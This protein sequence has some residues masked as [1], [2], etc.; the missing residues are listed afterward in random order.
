MIERFAVSNFKSIRNTVEILFTEG[1]SRMKGGHVSDDGC[2]RV[3]SIFGA[4]A[5]GK[6]NLIKALKFVKKI[7]TDPYYRTQHPACHWD[8]KDAVS[9]F[10]IDFTVSDEMGGYDTYSYSLDVATIE[11]GGESDKKRH[12]YEYEILREGLAVIDR[13]GVKREVFDKENETGKSRISDLQIKIETEQE[14]L[15]SYQTK[16]DLIV[17]EMTRAQNKLFEIESEHRLVL[18]VCK[19]MSIIASPED[20]VREK[21]DDLNI[22]FGDNWRTILGATA[23]EIWGKERRIRNVSVHDPSFEHPVEDEMSIGSKGFFDNRAVDPK[24]GRTTASLEE[25]LASISEDELWRFILPLM[26]LIHSSKGFD[27]S[28]SP[29][30]SN[31]KTRTDFEL[32]A[33]STSRLKQLEMMR[34][35]INDLFDDK[36]KESTALNEMIKMTVESIEIKRTKLIL[37]KNTDS[38]ILPV[39]YT[40]KYENPQKDVKETRDYDDKTTRKMIEKA[41]RWFVSTL[42]ILETDDYYLPIKEPNLLDNISA[43]LSS[44]DVGIDGLGW[45]NTYCNDKRGHYDIKEIDLIKSRL[46]QKDWERLEKCRRNSIDCSCSTSLIVKTDSELNLFTY[47]MGEE[48]VKKLVTY[49]NRNRTNYTNIMSESDG[50]RRLIELA[51]ILLPT[52]SEK[53]FVID[54]LDRR[55]HPLLTLRF[56]DL[57]LNDGNKNKQLIFVTHESRLLTTEIF[58]P[59]EI[60]FMSMEDG[61]S[62]ID[63]LDEIMKKNPKWFNKR[64]DRLYLEDL[65]LPGIP[66]IKNRMKR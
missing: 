10:E 36:R 46:S 63:S 9:K 30:L 4:N 55:L 35:K 21:I 24:T 33:M 19:L 51:S 27:R 60:W 8:M 61:T 52:D 66:N 47:Y 3:T 39:L 49:H 57:F 23:R 1:F 48:S 16:M 54:E 34:E 29:V 58:R 20:M 42:F 22:L 14:K 40:K 25:I 41:Y 12:L 44:L 62:S 6:S 11:I 7:I 37:K 38:K 17:K 56:I 18:R 15:E 2:L 31:F 45:K 13:F 50:T 26:R 53:V 64:T 28:E 65:K 59:D 43:A 5:S 32:F